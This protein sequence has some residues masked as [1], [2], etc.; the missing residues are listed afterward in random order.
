MQAHSGEITIP[1]PHLLALFA[2]EYE[3]GIILC[4]GEGVYDYCHQ[5]NMAM[6]MTTKLVINVETDLGFKKCNPLPQQDI[7]VAVHKQDY[8]SFIDDIAQ[9][10][11]NL[12][13]LED[14]PNLK[15]MIEN[16]LDKLM[17]GGLMVI[18][19]ADLQTVDT[20]VPKD[21][22]HIVD[23]C[24]PDQAI[25]IREK[26]SSAQPATRKGGRRARIM[27]RK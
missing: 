7:R 13:I 18:L 20:V 3:S 11:F 24:W 5:I 27:N 23:T 2:S 1:T 25:L 26:S 17:P 8:V 12:I 15:T 6:P 19:N 9:Y 10:F 22:W 21:Q 16:L 4:C 14:N